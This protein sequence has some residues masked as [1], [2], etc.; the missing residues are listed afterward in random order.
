MTRR[1]VL[2]L[3]QGTTSTRCL[4]F[5]SQG[6][7]VSIAQLEHHQHYPQPGWVEHD[8]L[9]IWAL[10]RRVILQALSD[11]EAEAAE[12]VGLGIT[13]QR[14]TTVIW[15]R[16]TGIP[17][18]R[19]IVWQDTRT[20]DLLARFAAEMPEA[21][22]R[23]RT[24]LPLAT[25]FSAPKVRWL[26]EARPELREG[27]ESGRL[28]FGTIDTWLVW[29][30]TGGVHGGRH[31]TDATNASRTMLMDLDSLSWDPELLALARLPAVA[32]PEIV[33]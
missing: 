16:T 24:G 32:L 10:A 27:L 7:M 8:A 3:D 17:V 1:F 26:L 11:V 2:A 9:E 5:D 33:P 15:D 14:E 25:Y 18:H 30:M 20:A 12:V 23:S 21:E 28:V 22:I 19:A 13:N 29:N 4:V 6:Q 31:L